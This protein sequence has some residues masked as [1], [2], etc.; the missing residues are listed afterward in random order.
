[1]CLG[2]VD[3]PLMFPVVSSGGREGERRN[4]L[5]L[6]SLFG[7]VGEKGTMRAVLDALSY[8]SGPD[9]RKRGW[10]RAR[11]LCRHHHTAA[12]VRIGMAQ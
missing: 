2:V 7:S 1:M 5:T 11:R 9:E 8:A 4:P 12:S 6:S 10:F 3:I